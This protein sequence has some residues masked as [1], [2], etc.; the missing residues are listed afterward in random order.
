MMNAS[1]CHKPRRSG[2][3]LCENEMYLCTAGV[4]RSK[5][6]NES[7]RCL[8]L[9]DG[10]RGADLPRNDTCFFQRRRTQ[11]TSGRNA[12]GR[13]GSTADFFWISNEEFVH[14]GYRYSSSVTTTEMIGWIS[15]H[16]WC[17]K[18]QTT[19]NFFPSWVRREILKERRSLSAVYI[20]NGD[21]RRLSK[22]YVV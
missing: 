19:N 4:V 14:G 10:A 16:P 8:L 11:S 20:N 9:T 5:I 6:P 22:H 12:P 15:T 1:C 18:Q 2:K 7:K 21:G 17:S 13:G 3:A